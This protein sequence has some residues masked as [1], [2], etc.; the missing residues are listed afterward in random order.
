MELVGW[1]YDKNCCEF[2]ADHMR[3]N[4]DRLAENK[5]YSDR[6]ELYFDE[7]D[8]LDTDENEIQQRF[9]SNNI[10]FPS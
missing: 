5:F 8:D 1:Q 6:P 3:I 2:Y 4:E 7:I 10:S 9:A